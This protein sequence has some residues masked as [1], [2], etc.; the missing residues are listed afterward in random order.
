MPRS[1]ISLL[2]SFVCL[3]GFVSYSAPAQAGLKKTFKKAK[4]KGKKKLKKATKKVKKAAKSVT[5]LSSNIKPL[6]KKQLEKARK[7]LKKAGKSIHAVSGVIKGYVKQ[8]YA[9]T[10][11]E[12]RKAATYT[13]KLANKAIKGV[14]KLMLAG[15]KAAYKGASNK[16][17]KKFTKLTKEV[18]AVFPKIQDKANEI[19]KYLRNGRFAKAA[20]KMK[21]LRDNKILAHAHK[22][23]HKLLGSSFVIVA[24]AS[25][26]VGKVGGGVAWGIA[27]NLEPSNKKSKK[28]KSTKAAIF[29]CVG[30]NVDF[31]GSGSTRSTSFGIKIGYLRGSPNN[32]SGLFIDAATA[33]IPPNPKYPKI[34]ASLSFGF[35]PPW[36]TIKNP[37]KFAQWKK[38]IT[39]VTVLLGLS[40]SDQPASPSLTLGA[41]WTE[42]KQKIK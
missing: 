2:L 10:E 7:Q 15:V 19:G 18:L 17:T 22:L 25:T 42:I 26:G 29:G 14:T 4:K 5:K 23:A 8:G 41:S 32:I 24:E 6:T 13:K 16:Y 1:F 9:L 39:P 33:G 34:Q 31:L 21:A 36:D 12:L 37:T 38:A 28:S 27:I 20:E 11:E 40:V 35:G 3:F 30:A